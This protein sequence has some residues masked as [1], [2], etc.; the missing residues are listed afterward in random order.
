MNRREKQILARVIEIKS[1]M[2]IGDNYA[3]IFQRYLSNSHS[4]Q[5]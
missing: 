1:K 3:P 2:K 4:K 5:L